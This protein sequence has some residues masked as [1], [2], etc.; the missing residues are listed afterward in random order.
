MEAYDWDEPGDI[1]DQ[2][3]VVAEGLNLFEEIFGYSSKS[4]IAPCYNWDIQ[5]EPTLKTNGVKIIQG[6]KNQLK[7]TGTF[8]NYKLAPHYFGE[9]NDSGLIY[10]IRNCFLEPSQL[11][12]KDWV[13]SCLA[14]IENAF[15]WK[16]PAVICS[17]RINYI[18][19]I[20]RGNRERGLSDLKRLMKTVLSKWP[21]VQ[22]I[23]TDQLD[24]LEILNT[25][26]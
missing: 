9:R 19:F 6:L 2:K 4:F 23:S 3:M 20:D 18:G 21:D 16:K 10:N 13:D 1:A 8:N 11:P 25:G 7:P 22:F 12:G 5:L 14:Q 24:E 17:H 15:M 26:D